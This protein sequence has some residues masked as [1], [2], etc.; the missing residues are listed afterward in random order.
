MESPVALGTTTPNEEVSGGWTVAN[1]TGVIRCDVIPTERCFTILNKYR[2]VAVTLGPQRNPKVDFGVGVTRP[3][4]DEQ[5]PS[6][7]QN[8]VPRQVSLT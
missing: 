3:T 2:N 7:H 4:S 8:R 5:Y 6:K 1:N